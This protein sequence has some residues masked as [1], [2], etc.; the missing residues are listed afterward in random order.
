MGFTL[1]KKEVLKIEDQEYAL[2]RGEPM[3][4]EDRSKPGSRVLKI[5][6]QIIK[7]AHANV[8]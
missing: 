2:L 4:P 8:S 3:V 6:V 1:L 5:P 7:A